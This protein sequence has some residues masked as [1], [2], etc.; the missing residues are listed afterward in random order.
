L[1]PVGCH[2][3][4]FVLVA[5]PPGSGKTTLATPLAAKLGLP[6]LAKDAIK[7][8]LMDTLDTPVTVEQSRNLG[9]AAVQAMLAVARTSPGAVLESTFYPETVPDLEDLPGRIVEIRCRC[10]RELALMRYRARGAGRHPGHLDAE[11]T[12]AELWDDRLLEPLGLGP[13]LE[14]DTTNEIDIDSLAH[15]IELLATGNSHTSR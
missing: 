13:L 10:P 6:L 7:E 3:A 1:T 2:A 11:R 5:G 14:V 8:A 9:R 15:Q 4:I 12:D